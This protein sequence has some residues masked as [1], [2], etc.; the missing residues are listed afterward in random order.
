MQIAQPPSQHEAPAC[1]QAFSF[2]PPLLSPPKAPRALLSAK[3]VSPILQLPRLLA[4]HRQNGSVSRYFLIAFNA[5]ALPSDPLVGA[6]P[7]L[8][9]TYFWIPVGVAAQAILD[10]LF[11]SGD[12]ESKTD[13]NIYHVENPICQPWKPFLTA[14]ATQL[15]LRSTDEDQ[16]D[17]GQLKPFLESEFRNLASGGVILNTTQARKVS[18]A[19]RACNGV[20]LGLVNRYLQYWRAVGVLA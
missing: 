4:M 10:I 19:L 8:D 3:N 13:E 9:G 20:G 1:I 18:R 17:F 16:E 14:L 5:R 6:L 2:C 7:A 11:T 15:D 12:G